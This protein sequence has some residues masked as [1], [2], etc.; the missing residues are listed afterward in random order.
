ML[1]RTV[2]PLCFLAFFITAINAGEAHNCGCARRGVTSRILEGTN[3]PASTFP[4]VGE[5]GD[6]S[7]TFCT[8]TLIA[9]NVVLCA[10]HCAAEDNGS[11]SLGDTQ[12]RFKLGGVTYNT[13]KVVIHPTYKGFVGDQDGQFDV[14]VLILS[15]SVP[16][17][18]PTPM[19]RKSPVVGTLLTLAGY[20]ELGNGNGGNG[21]YPNAGTIQ[22]GTTTLE[23]VTQSFLHW[24]FE[25][26]ESDT[27]PG[28]SGGPAFIDEGGVRYIAGITSGG[29]GDGF[30]NSSY[31]T[32]VDA[33]AAWV[34]SVIAANGGTPNPGGGGTTSLVVS[35]P[36]A[37]VNPAAPNEVVQFTAAGATG[38]TLAW[39]FGD[40]SATESGS[41]VQHAYATEGT[42]VVTLTAT[43]ASTNETATLTLSMLISSGNNP[44]GGTGGGG[45]GTQNASAVKKKF[46]IQFSNPDRSRFDITIA[47][48]AFAFADRFD[49]EDTLLDSQVRVFF[50]NEEADA[51]EIYATKS[52][53]D[54]GDG[55]LTWNYRKGSVR[56]QLRGEIVNEFIEGY[57]AANDDIQ[58]AVTIPFYIEIDGTRYGGS[59]VF[60][61]KA[62]AERGGTGK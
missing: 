9:P 48:P 30:N 46:S 17:V 53:N 13:K 58:T 43:K 20:G 56:Y 18:T 38:V 23:R 21:T 36:S 35:G 6:A 62:K 50:G 3:V 54:Y 41:N 25:Q 22:T 4:T 32:R 16:N 29:T 51:V 24:T 42:Y 33:I 7:G 37:S 10:A 34:D 12:G 45:G 59:Y 55:S 26:G 1:I 49:F 19:Y 2:T 61:Y 14:S 15:T 5:V 40:G 27:A 47:D 44:G 39:N 60:F 11:Q 31:D 52:V 28:D 8:G 57:G